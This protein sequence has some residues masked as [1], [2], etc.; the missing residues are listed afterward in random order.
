MSD[1]AGIPP[2]LAEADVDVALLDDL[3]LANHILYRQ[4]VVDGFGHVSQRHPRRPDRMLMSRSL[5]P[6]RV[7]RSDITMLDEEGEPVPGQPGIGYLERFIHSAIYALR[8]D[9]KAIVHSHSPSVVPFTTVSGVGLRPL[10][11]MCGFLGA[12]APLFEIRD[13][14]G[15]ASDLLVRDGAL[16]HA[17]ACCLGTSSLVLMR[18]HGSTIVGAGV[19]QAVYR[20]VYAE[21]N[22]RMQIAALGLGTPTYLSPEEAELCTASNDK[23]VDRCWELWAREVC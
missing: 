1:T 15:P 14:A 7:T 3:V 8:P 9:V 20:A 4:G 18:G 6:A 10:F 11:H 22:A 23:Q 5:A 16:G 12:G 2:H 19:R 17:L 21:V 13:S